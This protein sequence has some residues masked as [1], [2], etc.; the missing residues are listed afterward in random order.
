MGL[1]G[2][3][4]LV[5]LEGVSLEVPRS[6]EQLARALWQPRQLL[7]LSLSK[8][9]LDEE[10]GAVLIGHPG[11]VRLVSLELSGVASYVPWLPQL[12]VAG[13]RPEL[14]ALRAERLYVG[15]A[16]ANVLRAA[17]VQRALRALEL[18]SCQLGDGDVA[19][20]VES[21]AL[22]SVELLALGRNQLGDGAALALA[23][24]ELPALRELSLENNRIGDAGARALASAPWASRLEVLDLD[25]NVFGAEG[26]RALYESEGLAPG[27]RAAFGAS[28]GMGFGI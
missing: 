25:F 23:Q 1:I 14:R 11:L 16:L 2:A 5:G 7:A 27:L 13:A 18:V 9:G 15:G 24:A 12:L 8:V 17:R 22:A 3:R 6:V 4:A 21:G 10:L 26:R 20:L 28:G 19:A